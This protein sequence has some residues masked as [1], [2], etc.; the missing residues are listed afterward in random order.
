MPSS[1]VVVSPS[2]PEAKRSLRARMKERCAPRP[3]ESSISRAHTEAVRPRRRPTF[4]LSVP[5]GTSI[6]H[7]IHHRYPAG[8]APQMCRPCLVLGGSEEHPCGKRR[9]K[10][11]K[12]KVLRGG[13]WV[14][15]SLDFSPILWSSIWFHVFGGV[16]CVGSCSALRWALQCRALVI[17][18]CCGGDVIFLPCSV[19]MPA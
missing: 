7:F 2:R 11:A 4:A 17:A 16:R 5:T 15:C 9:E 1:R 13:C 10:S 8:A 12:C 14:C 19:C 3:S 6:D 18:A